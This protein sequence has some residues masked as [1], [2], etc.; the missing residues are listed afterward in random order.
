MLTT[1]TWLLTA[2]NRLSFKGSVL[3]ASLLIV[4]SPVL[5]A[6]VDPLLRSTWWMRPLMSRYHL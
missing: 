4:G 5:F 3:I 1:F 2:F 6:Q